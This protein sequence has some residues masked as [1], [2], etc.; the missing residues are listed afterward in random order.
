MRRINLLEIFYHPAFISLIIWIVLV[1]TIPLPVSKYRIKLVSEEVYSPNTYF[2]Y[3]DLDSNGSSE[4]ISI[5]LNDPG[6][7]KIIVYRDDKVMDQYNVAYHPTHIQSIYFGDYNGDSCE[8]IYI[9]TMND[10][11]LFLSVID[12]MAQRKALIYNRFIDSWTEAPQSTDRPQFV[13][14]GMIPDSSFQSH[15]FVFYISTGY[16]LQ[17]R[18]LYRYIIASDSLIK[19]PESY[20]TINHCVM[21]EK[22]GSTSEHTFLLSTS[23]TGNS[24]ETA[25]YSDL[26][27]WLMALNDEMKFSFQPVKSG[28]KPTNLYA[29][30]I[31]MRDQTVFLTWRDYFG[32]DDIK[33]MFCIYDEKGNKIREKEA[34]GYEPSFTNIFPNDADGGKSFYFLKNHDAVV[35]QLDTA[36]R[37]V[38]SY[39]LPPLS[40]RTPIA[41]LDADMDGHNEYFFAG[42]EQNSI[43]IS[44]DDFRNAIE[45]RFNTGNTSNSIISQ[46]LTRGSKPLFFIQM[47][48][49][50]RLLK[51]EKNPFHYLHLPVYLVLYS[52]IFLFIGFIYRIQ[53][54]RLDLKSATQREIAS[55]QM[56]AIKNQIDPH[57]T[58]NVLNSIGSLYQN[59]GDRRKADYI[60]G[61]Y[62]SLIR[63]TVISSDKIIITLEEEIDFVRNYIDIEQFR[64][65]N[66]FEYSI[67]TD[68]GVDMEARVPR[69]LIHTFVEN[70]IKYGLRQRTEGGK[71]NIEIKQN[72]GV[73]L[74]KIEDNGTGLRYDEISPGGTGKGLKIISEL[75]D[76]YYRLEKI[77]ITTSL[78]NITGQTGEILG[79]RVTIELPNS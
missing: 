60:F 79:T 76:L 74:I 71:L 51:Y 32:A 77:R 70:S 44:Q 7:T 75:T 26:H 78:N 3:C 25:P 55:L 27:A 61:K 34:E 22:P 67:D 53:K 24:D 66:S 2:M 10:K 28:R 20:A 4:K 35:E 48:T 68:P 23:A 13:A 9:F 64:S 19:S 49:H 15:D 21:I 18:N 39:T 42:R 41:F 38:K 11:A 1:L 31:N 40:F 72:A 59:E 5:D 56:K 45:Y 36:L 8:E 62:A 69:M 12:P 30:P 63:Q 54:H 52:I 29:I 47:Q 14:V 46:V 58:L 33:S 57:F 16:S 65:G 37:T 17:P 73:V 43:V 50:G 6:Q